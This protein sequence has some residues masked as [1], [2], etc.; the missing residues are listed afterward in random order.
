VNCGSSFDF[1][2]KRGCCVPRDLA[3][4]QVDQPLVVFYACE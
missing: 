2:G 4:G 1:E 3:G